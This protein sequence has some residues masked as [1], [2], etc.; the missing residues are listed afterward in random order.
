MAG[1]CITTRSLGRIRGRG[2][3]GEQRQVG[4]TRFAIPTT[5]S[6][7]ANGQFLARDLAFR[8]G[9]TKCQ[10]R[11][12][13]RGDPS[14][15]PQTDQAGS[16]MVSLTSCGRREVRSVSLVNG[17]VGGKF[18]RTRGEVSVAMRQEQPCKHSPPPAEPAL[19]ACEDQP[20]VHLPMAAPTGDWSPS[21][22]FLW[23]QLGI[24]SLL[25]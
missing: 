21:P 7:S 16:C 2:G 24:A 9:W 5:D 22:G 17:P 12:E 19:N 14:A 10:G 15:D 13:Q 25:W 11:K 20:L 3:G 18:Y 23:I 1:R 8:S 4:R 6:I